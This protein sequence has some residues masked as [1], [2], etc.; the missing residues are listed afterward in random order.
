MRPEE[1][2]T[3]R[4]ILDNRLN[5]LRESEA[6]AC[7]PRGWIRAIRE[8]LG[9]TTSQLAGRLGVVQSRVPALEQS[10]AK[11]TVT[12]ASLEKAA[13]ALDCRLV[14]ALVPRRP[15]EDLVEER[16][17]HKAKQ[18][19]E[20]TSHSMALEAQSVADADEEEQLKRLTRQLIEKAGSELWDGDE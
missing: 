17:R 7:P 8:A 11:K 12:L 3:A 9:M 15:L 19:L 2:A 13:N 16:A 18:W 14:Y 20:S 4:R 6:L 10:E 5:L 1:R